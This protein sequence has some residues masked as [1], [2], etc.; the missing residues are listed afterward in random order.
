MKIE[1]PLWIVLDPTPASDIGDIV[2]KIDDSAQ[3]VRVIANGSDISGRNV[4]LHAAAGSAMVDGKKRLAA[5]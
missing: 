5:R 1:F 4:T 2:W 3:L